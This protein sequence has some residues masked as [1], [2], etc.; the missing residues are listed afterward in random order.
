MRTLHV[1]FILHLFSNKDFRVADLKALV[2]KATASVKE[3]KKS[4][5]ATNKN[6]K[7]LKGRENAA[8]TSVESLSG[9]AEGKEHTEGK[10]VRQAS[11]YSPDNKI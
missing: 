9:S 8:F 7:D 1:F 5:G 2:D 3:L 10:I 4:L 11:T 6:V